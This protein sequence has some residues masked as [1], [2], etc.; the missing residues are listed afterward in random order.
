MRCPVHDPNV[1]TCG[2]DVVAGLGHRPANPRWGPHFRAS[3]V[4]VAYVLLDE[5]DDVHDRERLGDGK[6]DGA[7][8]LD[9][10]LQQPVD[11]DWNAVWMPSPT[12]LFH[13]DIEPNRQSPQANRSTRDC[14]LVM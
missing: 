2:Q 3:L 12:A 1:H 4:V 13:Q 14:R 9:E 11:A 10:A 6:V 5:G 8:P 7:R